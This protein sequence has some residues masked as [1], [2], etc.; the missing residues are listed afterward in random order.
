MRSASSGPV[1]DGRGT[2]GTG[3]ERGQPGRIEPDDQGGDGITGAA[4]RRTGRIGE[5]RAIGHGQEFLGARD[6]I[7]AFGPAPRHLCQGRP[8]RVGEEPQR[9][10]LRAD[11]RAPPGTH[12]P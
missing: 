7:G 9:S 4:T 3:G 12:L 6:P 2:A 1:L 11:H 8:F 10:L 5:T